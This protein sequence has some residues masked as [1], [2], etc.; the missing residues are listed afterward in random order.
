MLGP[1]LKL[2]L[3]MRP[4]AE[5]DKRQIAHY[6]LERLER[7]KVPQLYEQVPSIKRTFNGKLDRKY[8]KD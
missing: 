8:Y 3:Q 1:I 5:L 6:L 2:I 7:Y 4:E